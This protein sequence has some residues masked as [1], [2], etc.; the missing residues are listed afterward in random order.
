MKKI[1]YNLKKTTINKII[2]TIKSEGFCHL[3]NAVDLKILSAMDKKVR[4]NIK[5]IENVF[6]TNLNYLPICFADLENKN[7][8]CPISFS[9]LNRSWYYNKKK[10]FKIWFWKNAKKMPNTILSELER[11]NFILLLRKYFKSN[12]VNPYAQNGIRYIHPNRIN[13][14]AKLHQDLTFFT[15]N[16]SDHKFLTIWIPLNKCN[17]SSPG[18]K[19]YKKKIN[20]IYKTDNNQ[21][22]RCMIQDEEKKLDK[23]KFY[24]PVVN[25]GDIIIIKSLTIH[26]TNIKKN[27]NRERRSIELR[28]FS[29]NNIPK[30]IKKL[31]DVKF[32]F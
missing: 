23:K 2:K 10:N 17:K 22:H 7:F 29:K 8:K 25:K 26:S 18:I 30:R 21:K 6:Q 32:N 12:I 24:V 4:K 13:G 15:R 11:N 28:F 16:L 9:K 5:K 1:K 19:I 20:K 3:T 31:N 14:I 27:M